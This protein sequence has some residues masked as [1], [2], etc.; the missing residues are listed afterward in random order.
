M[1]APVPARSQRREQARP[2]HRRHL[3]RDPPSAVLIEHNPLADL[4]LGSPRE[5]ATS[6]LLGRKEVMPIPLSLSN[7]RRA[8]AEMYIDLT[9][10][11]NATT[12]PLRRKPPEIDANLVLVAVAVLE[13]HAE[14]KARNA[15]DVGRRLGVPRTSALRR[16]D[17]L[18]KIGLI[19]KVRHRYY[20]EPHRAAHIPHLDR[21][22]RIFAKS[23]KAIGPLLSDM[24]T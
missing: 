24:D 16:L 11:F 12:V 20:L 10:A 1:S 22:L 14:A 19:K 2:L 15:T 17:A 7:E 23:F 18:V 13:G 5:N 9:L 6:Q 21:F 3:R 4:S 8:L